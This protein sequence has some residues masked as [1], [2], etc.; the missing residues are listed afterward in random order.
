MHFIFITVFIVQS[1]AKISRCGNLVE[2]TNKIDHFLHERCRLLRQQQMD[3]NDILLKD[4]D[5][6]T[7]EEP[8]CSIVHPAG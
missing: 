8:H 1:F 5:V 7:N 4:Y 2:S 6:P 3:D